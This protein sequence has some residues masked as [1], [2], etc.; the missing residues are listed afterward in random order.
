MQK[1][2]SQR[3]KDAKAES[4]SHTSVGQGTESRSPTKKGIA[5]FKAE[6]LAENTAY[7]AQGF[8]P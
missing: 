6:S 7:N 8:Q 3:R 1:L 5:F 2:F 4:L